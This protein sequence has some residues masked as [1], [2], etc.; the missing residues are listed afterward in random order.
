MSRFFWI[1]VAAAACG[2]GDHPAAPATDPAPTPPSLVAP[3]PVTIDAA[4]VARVLE[5]I[6]EGD[7]EADYLAHVGARP[8][9]G[10]AIDRRVALLR[11]GQRAAAWG[12]VVVSPQGETYLMDETEG[13]GALGGLFDPGVAPVSAGDRVV[14]FGAWRAE[15]EPP[16]RWVWIADQ[17]LRLPEAS[18]P[19]PSAYAAAVPGHAIATLPELPDGALVIESLPNEGGGTFFQVIRAPGRA[20]EGWV[21]AGRSH[22]PAA[23]LLVLPGEREPYGAQDL[24]SERER[25]QL[26]PKISYALRVA[27]WKQPRKP[28]ELPVLRALSPPKRIQP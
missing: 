22:W 8:I 2:D 26:E 5:S 14:A 4:P 12:R 21:I 11:R 15:S 6:P 17:V 3:P 19:E 7:A 18:A 9:W 10:L 28:G 16:H 25:W 1:A 13:D 23:A 27:P 24:L 20:G